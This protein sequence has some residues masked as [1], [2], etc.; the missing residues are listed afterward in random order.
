[1]RQQKKQNCLL[2]WAYVKQL[3]WSYNELVYTHDDNWIY[4]YHIHL[5]STH[6]TN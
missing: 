3:I 5:P 4:V 2:F 1:M 6:E